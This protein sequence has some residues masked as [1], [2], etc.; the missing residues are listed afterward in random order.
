MAPIAYLVLAPSIQ[1][2]PTA[3]TYTNTVTAYTHIRTDRQ[4]DGRTTSG[5]PRHWLG[6][7]QDFFPEV[8]KLAGLEMKVLQRGL[9]VE[10][11]WGTGGK[12]PETEENC[13]NNA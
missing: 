8:G 13:K 12:P 6:R 1:P 7:P 10:P 5:Q 9:A 11:R 3:T 2:T 4:T